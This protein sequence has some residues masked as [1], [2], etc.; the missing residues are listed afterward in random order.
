MNRAKREVVSRAG[1]YFLSMMPQPLKYLTFGIRALNA[2]S[3]V[4]VSLGMP[5]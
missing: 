2:S 1:W 5:L 3:N 4:T